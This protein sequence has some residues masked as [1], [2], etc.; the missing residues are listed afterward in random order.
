MWWPWVR[1]IRCG[2][3]KRELPRI[4]WVPNRSGWFPSCPCLQASI[5]AD[6]PHPTAAS[7]LTG[8]S[9]GHGISTHFSPRWDSPGGPCTLLSSLLCQP[10]FCWACIALALLLTN[11]IPSP[12]LP[13]ALDPWY[14]PSIPNPISKSPSEEFGLTTNLQRLLPG[15]V[16]E[17]RR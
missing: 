9:G 16:Q 13:T 17:S 6:P 15:V 1:G 10:H 5:T 7:P 12:S 2:W 11:P 3:L 8:C 4:H 14:I